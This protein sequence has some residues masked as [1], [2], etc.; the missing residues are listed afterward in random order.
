M[1]GGAYLSVEKQS[2]YS[3]AQVTGQSK[4]GAS[5]LDCLISY[6]GH[7]LV[8]GESYPSASVRFSSPSQLGNNYVKAKIDN[9]QENGKSR[10]CGDTEM[11]QLNTYAY[12]ANW[13][14]RN[15]GP[16]TTG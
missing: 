9:T 5:P 7:S 10:L 8:Q 6:P 3:P 4:T 11:K 14:K 15:N 12:I 13:Y 1:W 16:N 2:M